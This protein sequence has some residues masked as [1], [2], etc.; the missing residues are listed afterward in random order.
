MLSK[1]LNPVFFILQPISR[2]KNFQSHKYERLIHYFRNNWFQRTNNVIQW[3]MLIL[4]KKYNGHVM[5]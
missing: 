1:I 3:P 2:Q 4:T 5:I